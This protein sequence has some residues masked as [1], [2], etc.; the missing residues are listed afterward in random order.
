M[1]DVQPLRGL[2]YAREAVGDLARVVSPPYDVIS[3]EEQVYYHALSPY[4]ILQ[5]EWGREFPNDNTLNNRYTRSAE[6]LKK[7]RIS[8]ILVKDAT[9]RYYLYH[10]TFD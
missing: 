3:P 6:L 8:G 9:S 2:K 4:N 5:V 1:V 10:Q 7:W